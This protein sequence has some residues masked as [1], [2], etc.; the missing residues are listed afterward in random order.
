MKN[1]IK[2]IA[3]DA[4][5]TLWLNE[6]YYRETEH[7]FF[8]LFN[9][10]FTDDHISN[11]LYQIEMQNMPWYGYGAKGFVLSMIETA[12]L[13]LGENKASTITPKIIE[14]GHKL[15]QKPI[16]LLEGVEETLYQLK[17]KYQLVL[18]TK[19]DLLDQ[20]RK[21]NNSGLKHLFN[22]I[23]IMSDKKTENYEHL[24]N[25]LICNPTNFLMVGN[26]L[27]SDILPVLDIGGYTAYIPHQTTWKHEVVDTPINH[28]KMLQLNQINHLLNYFNETR[29]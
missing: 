15:L 16:T 6:I 17:N 23:E 1:K 12:Y 22:H 4:D 24:L 10:L 8:K 29:N 18:A 3:F 26:S 5:D 2:V 14:L 7:H 27:K 11:T 28:K 20:E 19:G 21:I 13:L 9:N 25:R